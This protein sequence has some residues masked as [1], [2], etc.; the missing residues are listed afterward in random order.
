MRI[1]A[2]L[3]TWCEAHSIARAVSCCRAVA[4]EVIVADGG[5]SDAT[6]ACAEAAGARVVRSG[7]GRGLQLNAGARASSGEVLLFVHADAELPPAARSAML[8]ALSNPHVVGG[9][10]RLRF[11]PEGWSA[12][13]FTAANDWRRRAFRIYYGDSCIFVRRALFDALGGFPELP[14][15]ED[16]EFVR[17]LEARGA[18][19]YLTEPEVRV[20]SRRFIE[21]PAR[22][23]AI[24][25]LLQAL[26][27]AGVPA[28]WLARFYAD[29]RQ[30]RGPARASSSRPP[31]P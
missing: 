8:K 27:S 26:Y 14:L 2:I 3:P 28:P 31:G 7:K 25:T 10:F 24:W 15:F 13:V 22:T 12:R 23:L 21:R 17:R 5:S 1:S 29:I 6:V 30:P 9:N 11:V 4:D 19:A 18:T 16:Y 20:S